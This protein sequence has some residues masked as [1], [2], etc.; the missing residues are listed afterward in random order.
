MNSAVTKFIICSSTT[1]V[2]KVYTY[3][4]GSWTSK[5]PISTS[6]SV[7]WFSIT[8]DWNTLIYIDNSN[9]VYISKYDISSDLYTNP[10]TITLNS[11]I[12]GNYR[13]KISSD[14]KTFFLFYKTVYRYYYN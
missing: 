8:D 13:I 10:T 1:D 9:N 5:N 14:T 2:I 7:N 3:S 6:P 12:N 4:A 11:A